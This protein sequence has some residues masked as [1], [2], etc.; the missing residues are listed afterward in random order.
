ME[1]EEND[2]SRTDRNRPHSTTRVSLIANRRN[3][4]SVLRI[5]LKFV[6]T[7][8][9]VSLARYWP[10]RMRLKWVVGPGLFSCAYAGARLIMDFDQVIHA[11]RCFRSVFRAGAERSV[12]HNMN[13]LFAFVR[14]HDTRAEFVDIAM[15]AEPYTSLR[16]V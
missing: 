7:D 8:A 4:Y 3:I 12:P 16:K 6:T 11:R 10:R 2:F 14:K 13:S 1:N 5:E 15:Q 9:V